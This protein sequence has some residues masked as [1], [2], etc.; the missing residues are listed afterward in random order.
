MVPEKNLAPKQGTFERVRLEEMM[1]FLATELHKGTSPFFSPDAS[2]EFKASLTKRLELRLA[3]LD[4][5][6]KGKKFL[7]GDTFTVADAYAF[8]CLGVVQHVAKIDL[9]P[10][11]ELGPYLARLAA[12]PAVKEALAA[13][14]S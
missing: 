7:M 5:A 13:E 10:Y 12:L 6:L 8:W 1:N 11:S 3:V 14:A 4:D 2:P 9:A